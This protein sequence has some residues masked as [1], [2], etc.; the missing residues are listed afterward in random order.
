MNRLIVATRNSNKA[1][2]I[3]ELL[4]DIDVH[5]QTLND[6]PHIGE[7]QETGST[8]EENALLKAR[9]VFEKTG[10]PALADDSGL[11]VFYLHMRPGVLSA[12]YSGLN[13]TYERNNKKILEE[14]L[15]VPDRR[16]GARFRCVLAFVANRVE[17]VVE[18]KCSGKIVRQPRGSNGFGYD[19]LFLPVGHTQTFAELPPDSKNEISH[20]A[21]ALDLIRPVLREYFKK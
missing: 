14:I 4:K 16:R 18:G 2:E 21:K 12:R 6:L 19:P 8:F 11:E 15:G 7:I 9:A 17:R 13:A 3:K 10:L 5:I 20:R 1:R